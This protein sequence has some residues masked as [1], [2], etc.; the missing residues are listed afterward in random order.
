MAST[1]PKVN[2]W[3]AICFAA[4]AGPLQPHQQ[5]GFE[6]GLGAGD[7]G[8]GD[9]G[10]HGFHFARDHGGNFA[11]VLLAGADIDA[12]EAAILEIVGEGIDRIAQPALLAHFLEQPRR[13]AAAQGRD[14]DLSHIEIRI[15]ARHAG[16]RIGD[17][18]LL[19]ILVTR[20]S[21]PT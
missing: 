16:K 7:F 4:G 3:P 19:Q 11:R 18:R 1:R 14:I 2:I 5:A 8:V 12:A 6:L 9:A 10:R 17:V 13:H 15:G 20:I 21:P